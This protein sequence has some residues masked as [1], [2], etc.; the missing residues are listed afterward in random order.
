M[1]KSMVDNF[2]VF[3]TL[4]DVDLTVTIIR[5]VYCGQDMQDITPQT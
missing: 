4:D 3:Y 1:H 2:V 5:I